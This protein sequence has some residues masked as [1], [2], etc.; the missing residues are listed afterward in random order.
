[1]CKIPFGGL[2]FVLFGWYSN[3]LLFLHEDVAIDITLLVPPVCICNHWHFR[4]CA[5]RLL[6]LTNI[7]LT[8]LTTGLLYENGFFFVILGVA[9]WSDFFFPFSQIHRRIVYHLGMQGAFADNLPCIPRHCIKE[10]KYLDMQAHT[11]NLPVQVSHTPHTQ[12]DGNN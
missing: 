10:R 5:F 6:S 11:T 8:Y 2:N 3:M 9:R 7:N 4:T 12:L 1:M